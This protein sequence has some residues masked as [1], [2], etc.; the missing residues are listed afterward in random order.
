LQELTDENAWIR[1]WA[2]RLLG[3]LDAPPSDSIW[4]L[5][6]AIAREDS[7]PD[8][9]LQLALSCQR[10]RG[11]KEIGDILRALMTRTED[12]N[13][14]AIPL[15]IWVAYEPSLVPNYRLELNWLTEHDTAPLVRQHILPR[16][17]RRLNA[18]GQPEHLDA[19]LRA[20]A[21]IPSEGMIPAADALLEG[22]R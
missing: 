8:V 1:G 15:M 21:G 20:L 18:T 2:V 10:W 12:V 19:A 22:M 13:D 5:L 3:Q 17:L 9:R 16:A 4:K 7:S 11:R 14:P 6:A